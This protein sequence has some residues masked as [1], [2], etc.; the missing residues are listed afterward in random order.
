MASES[1]YSN[2]KKLGPAQFKTIQPLGSNKFGAS[3]ASKALY[4][5]TAQDAIVVSP[6]LGATGQVEFLNVFYTGNA[7]IVDDVLRITSGTYINLELE[8]VKIIDVDN[9]YITPT[10][11]W[12]DI[13]GENAIIMAWVTNKA[14]SDGSQ[15]VVLPPIVGAATEAKQDTQILEAI[16]TNTKLDTVIAK[17]FAT[18]AKQDT[19]QIAINLLAKLTDTQ[20]VSIATMPSTPVTGTFWQTTQPVS[21]PLTDTELRATAV[22]VSIASIPLGTGA[23]TEAKQDTGNTSLSGI[24]TNTV[25]IP[26]V[27]TTEGGAQPSHGVVVMG[28]TGAGVVRHILVENNGRQVTHVT[29]SV[30][31]TGASTE[32]T[33][34][35]ILADTAS[36]DLKD[37]AT[38]TTLAALSAKLPAVLGQTTMANSLAVTIASNQSALSVTQAALTPT[39]QEILNL[40]N[41][42]QTFTAP[43]GAKWCKINTDDTNT[44]NIRVKIGGTATTSSGVQFQPGRSEDYSAVGNISV[45][46]ET[47]ATNQK[48]CVQFGA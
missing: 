14:N 48:I 10:V 12:T 31:P 26:N 20:P 22:P 11:E 8:I 2:Q 27:I 37:F 25:N 30:L 21:G 19:L 6:I 45:I 29:T 34:A 9:F 42:A 23:A 15:I 43:A 24:D 28:H 40:T 16:S 36:L 3:V 44:A 4:E 32:T 18:A 41:S 5:K 38:E 13:S 7:A 35:A 39:F 33:L 46:C 47:A 1:G 17:D